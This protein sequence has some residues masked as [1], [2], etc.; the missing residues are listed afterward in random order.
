MEDPEPRRAAIGFLYLAIALISPIVAVA[1][2]AYFGA[3][4][5]P[6]YRA[7]Q[8]PVCEEFLRRR[9]QLEAERST[10]PIDLQRSTDRLK[11]INDELKAEGCP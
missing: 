1:L 4:P 2:V 3:S 8:D 7:A 6:K 9:E 11:G 10:A 5:E